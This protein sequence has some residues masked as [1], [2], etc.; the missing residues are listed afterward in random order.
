MAARHPT[1]SVT[2]RMVAA[3]PPG[4]QLPHV[5]SR[6]S[7]RSSMG[8][9]PRHLRVAEANELWNSHCQRLPTSD[10]TEHHP[11][12]DPMTGVKHRG[13]V[14][15]APRGLRQADHRSARLLLEVRQ[16]HGGGRNTGAYAHGDIRNA[17]RRSLWS[18]DATSLGRSTRIH[19]P[20][21]NLRL[22]AAPPGSASTSGRSRNSA[23][24][25]SRV[26]VSALFACSAT[27]DSL[28]LPP[29]TRH[30]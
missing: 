12:S 5:N 26:C 11:R 28:G 25:A 18:S 8:S 23:R 22:R 13:P 7:F 2:A 6:K 27:A 14:H 29:C 17:N 16:R 1:S 24:K 3:D 9:R 19:P 4:W 10:H 30:R 20:M 21:I 15:I